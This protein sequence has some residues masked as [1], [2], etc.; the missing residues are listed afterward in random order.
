M[1]D[2]IRTL[3]HEGLFAS[4]NLLRRKRRPEGL[5]AFAAFL[6]CRGKGGTVT[7]A[8]GFTRKG[9]LLGVLFL[10]AAVIIYPVESLAYRPFITEDA[11]VAGKGVAQLEGSWDYL[12]W[13]NDD[14]ENVFLLVPVYGITERIEL[15]LE[16]PYL[17]HNPQEEKSERGIGDIIFVGKFLLFEEKDLYPAFTVKGVVKT[18][19]GNE[20]KGLGSGDWDYSIV[21]V[22][23]KTIG[24][25]MFHAMLGYTFVGDNGDENIRNVYLYGIAVDYILTEKFHFVSEIVGNGHPDR[26]EDRDP[27]SGLLGITYALSEKVILDSGIRYGFNDSTPKWNFLMGVSITF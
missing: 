8:F 14:K 27:I 13:D 19:S 11:G 5:K 4:A 1:L 9:Y 25:F 6:F 23:S 7:K 17:L 18:D 21:A 3:S 2:F 20:E 24:A 16:I 15:S 22:T 26:S 10:L 12:S